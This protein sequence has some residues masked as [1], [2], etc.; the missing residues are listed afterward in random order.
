MVTLDDTIETNG[1]RTQTI[2]VGKFEDITLSLFA[3]PE[4]QKEEYGNFMNDFVISCQCEG[5]VKCLQIAQALLVKNQKL[6]HFM[7]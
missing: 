6:W 2:T 4:I 1:I 7:R 5:Y 3:Y